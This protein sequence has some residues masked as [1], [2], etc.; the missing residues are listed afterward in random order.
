MKT[1]YELKDFMNVALFVVLYYA[2]FFV[3][4]CAGYLP[5][6]MPVLPLIT[7]IVCGI[8]FMLFLTRAKKPG[9]VLLMGLICGLISLT[10]GSG[11]W[12]LLTALAAGILAELILWALH[13][14]PGI[15]MIF[16]YAA[17]ALWDIGFS[18]RLYL[19]SFDSYRASLVEQYGEEYVSEML[20]NV[21]GLGFW[22][23]V[24]LTLIG[25]LLGGLLGCA[26]LRRHF[27]KI[28]RNA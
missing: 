3:G 7:G 11:L 15:K 19:A 25:G 6:L 4:M 5:I 20:A 16:V 12:P 28:V 23:G 14:T 8:P 13:Y 27:R 24:V 17:F 2:A 21:S 18:L 1:K 10:M 26:V 9:M 22:G